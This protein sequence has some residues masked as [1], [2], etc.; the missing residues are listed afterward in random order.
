MEGFILDESSMAECLQDGS[1][2]EDIWNRISILWARYVRDVD[3]FVF[4]RLMAGE[5]IVE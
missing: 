4:V 3:V 1:G 5:K 2:G